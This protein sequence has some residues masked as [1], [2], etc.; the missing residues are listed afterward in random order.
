M[1]IIPIY[2]QGKNLSTD[3]PKAFR[4]VALAETLLKLVET[5]FIAQ[6]RDQLERKLSDFQ[7]AY[8]KGRGTYSAYKQLHANFGKYKNF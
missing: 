5:V 2:K 7:H 3:N 4:P 6:I 1:N 8:R